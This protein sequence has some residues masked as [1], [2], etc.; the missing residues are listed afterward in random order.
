MWAVQLAVVVGGHMLGAF[1][2]HL[3][4]VARRPAAAADRPRLRTLQVRQL[5]LAILM[6][7]LTV[8]TLW[9]LGQAIVTTAPRA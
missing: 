2:G 8:T 6:V 5:P 3:A 7:A 4:A 9:S 1:A